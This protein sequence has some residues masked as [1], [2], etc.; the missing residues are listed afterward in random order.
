MKTQK[1]RGRPSLLDKMEN[2]KSKL[3]IKVSDKTKY[4]LLFLAKLQRKSVDTLIEELVMWSADFY[5][6]GGQWR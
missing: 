4:L 3:T 6:N 5:M 1:R 2:N